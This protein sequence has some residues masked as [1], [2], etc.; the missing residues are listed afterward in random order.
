MSGHT[1]GVVKLL[2]LGGTQEVIDSKK[3]SETKEE[4]EKQQVEEKNTDPEEKKEKPSTVKLTDEQLRKLTALNYNG[5]V[6]YAL[7]QGF[8]D[9]SI[10]SSISAHVSYFEDENTASF[11]LKESLVKEKTKVRELK[12]SL[13]NDKD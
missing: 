5:R 2:S 13:E 3:N 10:I 4:G 8:L 11:I 6:D 1:E 7:D 9:L 12:V